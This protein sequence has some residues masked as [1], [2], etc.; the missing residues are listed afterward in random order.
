M[1]WKATWSDV[2]P[3]GALAPDSYEVRPGD[4]RAAVLAR[5]QS[6]AGARWSPPRGKRA[7]LICRS[8]RPEEL[9]MLAS[10]VEK[11]TGVPKSADRWPACS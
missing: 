8:R 1:C 9:V 3:E 11:E 6:G 5:M 2:P 7:I 4:D 10:I